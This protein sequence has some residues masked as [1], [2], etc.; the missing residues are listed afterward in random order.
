MRTAP[1][2]RAHFRPLLLALLLA[3]CGAHL[4]PQ[5]AAAPQPR[6]AAGQTPPAIAAA[7]APPEAPASPMLAE[8][9]A[10]EL[11]AAADDALAL[12][13]PCW[14]RYAARA[15]LVLGPVLHALEEEGA[16]RELVWVALV[17][18]GFS[19]YALSHAGAL[20][21]WQLM[22]G[23]ARVLGLRTRRDWNPRRALVPSTHAAARYLL[24]LRARF[25]NWPL[26]LA[27]YHMGPGALART[28]ARAPWTP[29]D[30]LAALPVREIT[31]RYVRL[32]LGL[33]R[34]EATDRLV[35]PEPEPTT[36]VRL[37]PPVDLL[38][39]ARLLDWDAGELF[40]LNPGLEHAQ[41][42]A[43][44]RLRVPEALAPLVAEAAPRARPKTLAVV[45]RPGDTLWSLARRVHAPL[46]LLRALNPGLS[47]RRLRP[48]M[49]VRVPARR[50]LAFA[51]P[52]VNPLVA[53]G[54]RIRYVVRRG[55]T[56][57]T[58]ARRFGVRPEAIARMN[59]RRLEGVLRP[60]EALLI[61]APPSG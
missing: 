60:G 4:P 52:R 1:K 19:P 39:L 40:M 45:V 22:P 44:I 61:V 11:D 54:R 20:G 18:S 27:A 51:A 13:G 23:T 30:G 35:L 2:G 41:A 59:G 34:A 5:Q 25:G 50:D 10:A 43:P 37:D 21:L 26:A 46:R 55:D 33:V 36:L 31:R 15:R 56:L 47:P 9:D 3:G 12:Y 7:P 38:R 58:I 16:P 6:A 17:E 57:W 32:I 29:A 14:P 42:L 49:R 48:G 24:A 28:L 53:R 8:L